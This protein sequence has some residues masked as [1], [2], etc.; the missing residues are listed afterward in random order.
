MNFDIFAD[1]SANVPDEFIERYRIG[2]VPYPYIVNGKE[3]SAFEEGVPFSDAAK[4]FYAELRGGAEIKTSLIP[5]E[6]FKRAMLPALEAGRDALLITITASLSGSH[7]QAKQAC[8]ELQAEFPQRTV[9]VVDS[10]NA[11]LGQGLLVIGAARL[12]EEGADIAACA[13]WVENSR[14]LLNSQVTVA[15]LKYL[16]RSGR[17]SG[18]LAFAG[19]I[20][21]LK[22]MLHADG[23]SP[24]KLVVYGKEKGRKRAL[25][26]MIKA[27]EENVIAPETQ[28]IAIAHADCEEE[29]L[30]LKAA[31]MERGAQDVI[32]EYYDL[33]TGSHVGPGTLALF[34]FGK[35]RRETLAAAPEA[36]KLR[37]R[38]PIFAKK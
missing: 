18:I 29:A 22:P 11:S 7:A 30:A 33:C 27:F 4:R 14:Y 24:A 10:A 1:S 20:L 38:R 5:K 25:A 8:E 12:R 3:Y 36:K 16:H 34:F 37:I 17:V 21:N 26:Q 23:S 13:A 31:V 28:T 6:A 19:A 9:M 35:D 15:E 32:I 2:I